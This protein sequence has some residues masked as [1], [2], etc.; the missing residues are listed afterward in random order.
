AAPG[1][2]SPWRPQVVSGLVNLG[3]S[4]KDA[5]AAAEAV[6]PEAADASDVAV[7]LRSA[8]RRLSRT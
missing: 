2:E 6:A 5:E 1:A 4:A 8:L 7:L 3:W